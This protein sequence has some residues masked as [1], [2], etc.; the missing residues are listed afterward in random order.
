MSPPPKLFANCVLVQ[1]TQ[2]LIV[3]GNSLLRPLLPLLLDHLLSKT[4]QTCE[5]NDVLWYP[6][7][8]AASYMPQS[9]GSL[10]NKHPYGRTSNVIV[11]QLPIRNVLQVP[12][13]PLPSL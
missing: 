8:A 10:S 2:L 5:T 4:I 6:N 3:L 9:E 12:L 13:T 1:V 7:S 11:G